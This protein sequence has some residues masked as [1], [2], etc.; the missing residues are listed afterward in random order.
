MIRANKFPKKIKIR[1]KI[2]SRTS[3]KMLKKV[4]GPFKSKGPIKAKT[5]M[6]CNH[7]CIPKIG[8]INNEIARILSEGI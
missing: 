5:M 7:R 2:A 3:I 8:S 1:G 4:T 6:S